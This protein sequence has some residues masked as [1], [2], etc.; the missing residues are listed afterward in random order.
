MPIEIDA[1]KELLQYGLLGTNKAVF[2]AIIDNVKFENSFIITGNDDGDDNQD[3]QK[4]YKTTQESIDE[5]PDKES[6]KELKATAFPH[7]NRYY[8]YS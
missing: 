7:F 4:L 2:Q 8:N 1:V 6:G 5:N 3:F